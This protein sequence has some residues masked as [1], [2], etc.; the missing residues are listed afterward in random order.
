M[1]LFYQIFIP[2]LLLVQFF[3]AHSF[4][5]K[6]PGSDQINLLENIARVCNPELSQLDESINQH[7][8]KP[9]KPVLNGYYAQSDSEDFGTGLVANQP[10]DMEALNLI[11]P[12]LVYF[13]KGH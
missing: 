4:E 12:Q 5:W 10:P 1:R 7:L 8:G 3:Y 9:E 6:S 11:N 13:L 2:L